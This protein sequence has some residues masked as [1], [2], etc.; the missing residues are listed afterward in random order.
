[1]PVSFSEVAFNV[2][3]VFSAGAPTKLTAPI[4]GIYVLAGSV[5]W[6]SGKPGWRQL[7]IDSVKGGRVATSLIPVAVEQYAYNSVSTV[8]NLSAG[9]SAELVANQSSG[10]ALSFHGGS[11]AM[12]WVGSG[13]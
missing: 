11:F 12:N 2:G 3:G 10:G 6:D 13:G 7:E 1:M 9:E 4:S 5:E 8:V